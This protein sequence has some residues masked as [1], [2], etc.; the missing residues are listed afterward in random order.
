MP[1][2][3]QSSINSQADNVGTDY[4]TAVL[5]IYAGTPPANADTPLSGNT[6]LVAHT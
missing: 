3:N 5:T 2:L 6:A 4:A 1:S